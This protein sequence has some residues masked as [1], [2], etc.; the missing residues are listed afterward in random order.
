MLMTLCDER[1]KGLEALQAELVK[2]GLMNE[3]FNF[4]K[5]TSREKVAG[6]AARRRSVRRRPRPRSR[7]SRRRPPRRPGA[8]RG[9]PIQ[10]QDLLASP[11][12]PQQR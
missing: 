5:L 6:G 3:K 10:Q 4:S 1:Q 9:N 11:P 8:P 7:S 2:G 12:R